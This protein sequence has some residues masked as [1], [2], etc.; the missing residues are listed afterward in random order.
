MKF[1]FTAVLGADDM[2]RALILASIFPAIGGVLRGRGLGKGSPGRCSRVLTSHGRV[3]SVDPHTTSGAWHIPATIKA[4]A[5][6]QAARGHLAEEQLRIIGADVRRSRRKGR[7]S[8]LVLFVVDASGS[9]GARRRIETVKTAVLSL[10]VD[11][12]QRRDRV[13]MITFRRDSAEFVLPPT[14]SVEAAA[15]RLEELPHGGRTPLVKGLECAARVLA[16]EAVKDPTRRPIVV[17]LSDG[18]ATVGLGALARSKAAADSLAVRG[19]DCV[20][21]DCETGLMRLGLAGDL[22]LGLGAELVPM[23]ELD[24]AAP[25]DVVRGSLQPK[26]VA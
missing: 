11:A 12:Y 24:P 19:Y 8:N 7:E 5:P 2:V 20:V 15:V 22:V 23:A 4:A 14:G 10:L 21:V 26:E 13:G 17:L 6:R 3:V 1:P 16:T 18:R 9:V 25:T